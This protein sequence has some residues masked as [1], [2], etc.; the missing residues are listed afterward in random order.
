MTA[1]SLQPV[2]SPVEK[3]FFVEAHPQM[4]TMFLHAIRKAA[5]GSAF[6]TEAPSHLVNRRLILTFV[7]GAWG[8][9]SGLRAA[10]PSP[11]MATRMGAFIGGPLY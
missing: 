9:E 10:Q 3:R 4:E 2:S 11:I 7:F 1:D 8:F 6:S 5:P